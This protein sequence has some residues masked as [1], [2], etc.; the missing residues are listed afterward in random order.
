MRS[1]MID[2][3]PVIH[4]SLWIVGF[5]LVLGALSAANYRA[6][7][8][9]L[10]LR[11][12]LGTPGFHLALDA[13]LGLVCLGL[14][15]SARTWWERLLWGLLA[16]AFAGQAFWLWWR[17]RR[18]GPDASRLSTGDTSVEGRAAASAG[19]GTAGRRRRRLLGWGLLVA[20]LLLLAGWG[21]ATAV[22]LLGHARSLQSHL[23]Q[24]DG[25]TT[26][27]AGDL[28]LAD[29]EL[30]GTHLSGMRHDLAAVDTL[31]GS[32]LPAA[33]LFWWV[34]VHGGDLAASP[35]LLDI[36]LGVV[37]AADRTF[38]ALSPALDLVDGPDGGAASALALGRRLLPILVAAQPELQI[39][40]QELDTVAAARA[41]TDAATLS[42]QVA[43]YLSRLDRYLPWFETA[44]DGALLAP[45]LLGADGPRTYLILAQNNHEL[46]PTGG[47]ISGVGEL[48]VEDGRLVSLTFSDSYAVD[49]LGV[50]HDLTP[51][52]FQDVLSGQLWF[53]RDANWDADFPTSAS[54]AMEIYARDRGTQTDGVI[55]LDLAALQLLVDALG[56]LQVPGINEP[57]TGQGVVQVIQ[58]Q[59]GGPVGDGWKEWWLHRKDFMGQIASATMARL[60]GGGSIQPTRVAQAL[61]QAIDEKHLL[62]YVADPQ[63]GRLLRERNWDGSLPDPWSSSDVL[64]VVD[65]NVGFNKVNPNIERAIEYQVDLGAE[66][67]PLARL[68]VSYQ[69]RSKQPVGSCIQEA[70]YG[71]SYADMMDRCY[72]NYLRVYVPA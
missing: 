39:V 37:S 11:D 19:A 2:W 20:G 16:A 71:D 23:Q 50:P 56:P 14:L 18:R 49:N 38:Q 25:L 36:G 54:R 41:Q 48:T 33:R 9:K 6:G 5:A 32:F 27:A 28:S 52:D 70:R 15:F 29:L 69:N 63:A 67:K 61:K 30:A 43:G 46:R 24:L 35:D 62:L 59:W 17:G 68:A 64:L 31:V 42:P 10:R 3:W 47:F 44:V 53:I 55:A 72:W 26:P 21:I 22:D 13:G 66:G 60:S 45:E 8:Q 34:P 57:V 7:Q 4:N 1:Q 40:K 12:Q 58:E 51:A 65:T